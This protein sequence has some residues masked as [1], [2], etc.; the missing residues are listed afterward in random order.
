MARTGGFPG[1][2]TVALAVMAL[3]AAAW[4]SDLPTVEPGMPKAAP[5]ASQIVKLDADLAPQAPKS[6]PPITQIV[7]LEPANGETEV[8]PATKELKVTFDRPMMSGSAFVGDKPFFP[9]TTDKPY[10]AD[11]F[12]CALPV[13]LEPGRT[14][15]LQ[16]GADRST[17]FRSRRGVAIKPVLWRFRTSGTPIDH[18][19][20]LSVEE[21]KERAVKAW[22]QLEYEI[23]HHYAFSDVRHIDW[24]GSIRSGRKKA[25]HAEDTREWIAAAVEALRD[26]RD[27]QVYFTYRGEIR[28]VAIRRAEANWNDYAEGDRLP[29][30]DGV[31]STF[32]FTRTADGVG[33]VTVD[34][35]DETRESDFEDL[36]GMMS[37]L[38]DTKALVLDL[39]RVSNASEDLAARLAGWFTR[40]RRLYALESE[41][42]FMTKGGWKSARKCWL[43]PA[44]NLMYYPR[45]VLVLTGPRLTSGGELL[46]MMLKAC[47]NVAVVGAA[48]AGFPARPK[49]VKL[50][51][52]VTLYLPTT[53]C[54]LPDGTCVSMRGVVPD[55]FL[56]PGKAAYENDDP[57]CETAILL[58]RRSAG[59]VKIDDRQLLAAATTR[60]RTPV[61]S[62]WWQAYPLDPSESRESYGTPAEQDTFF[63]GSRSTSL[64]H[65]RGG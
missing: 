10:Y 65:P 40:E 4:G 30:M 5:P 64:S 18:H 28:R 8:S 27:P 22:S 46:V 16:I 61:L 9:K 48:T 44:G 53:K 31:N 36:P 2:L 49:G 57:V 33:Y 26:T 50:A 51:N 55:V 62:A 47:P 3:A 58:A 13:S 39:R 54:T 20:G 60:R 21:F 29:E 14:Y 6:L 24:I 38:W 25:A 42:D 43:E 35:L 56:D 63:L 12:T 7:K 45:R 1:R 23:E 37:G 41:R 34:D 15:E 32:A 19:D 59:V 11:L 17:T 52:G